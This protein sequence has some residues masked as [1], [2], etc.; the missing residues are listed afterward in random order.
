ML[1]GPRIKKGKVGRS[2]VHAQE[3]TRK[4]ERE[5]ERREKER[6]KG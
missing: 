4:R 2:N 1:L 5:N 3:T 6:E